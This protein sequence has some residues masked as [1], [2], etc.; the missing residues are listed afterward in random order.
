MGLID[1]LKETSRREIMAQIDAD[2]RKR[3]ARMLL[4]PCPVC[5]GDPLVRGGGGGQHRCC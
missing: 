2:Q 4:P 3:V 1:G 5:G